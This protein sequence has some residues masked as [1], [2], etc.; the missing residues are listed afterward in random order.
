ME[1]G[2]IRPNESFELRYR[3]R[4]WR[5]LIGQDEIVESVRAALDSGGKRCFFFY[6]PSGLGKTTAARLIASHLGCQDGFDGYLERDAGLYTGIDKMRE[7]TE[8]MRYKP[9]CRGGKK[10]VCLDEVHC[11]SPQA[12]QALLKSV[13]EPPSF[14]YWIFCTTKLCGIPETLI[15]RCARYKFAPVAAEFIVPRLLYVHHCEGLHLEPEALRHI[16]VF[17]KGIPRDAL[18][19]LDMCRHLTTLQ[20][21]QCRLRTTW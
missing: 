12:M 14:G 3:P 1:R 7:L 18:T 5:E 17:A 16:A 19:Y 15:N 11:L 8:W 4:T 21:V 9:M 10:A 6:G 2:L 20:E 13:E